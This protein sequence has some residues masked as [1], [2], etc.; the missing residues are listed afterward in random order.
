MEKKFQDEQRKRNL[1]DDDD[2]T[3]IDGVPMEEN[4][5]DVQVKKS[6][7]VNTLMLMKFFKMLKTS[8]LSTLRS[9]FFPYLEYLN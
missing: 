5:D 3:D 7:V 8:V 1:L 2:D 4:E 6:Q 9:F